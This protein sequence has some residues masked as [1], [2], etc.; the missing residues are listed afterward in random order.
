MIRGTICDIPNRAY[1]TETYCSIDGK[2]TGDASKW[3]KIYLKYIP[4][5]AIYFDT[6]DMELICVILYWTNIQKDDAAICIVS[7]EFLKDDSI[8]ENTTREAINKIEI[9]AATKILN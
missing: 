2:C 3:N 7:N 4:Y 8:I 5:C 1:C 9:F 6:D